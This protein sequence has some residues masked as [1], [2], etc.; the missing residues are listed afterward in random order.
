MCEEQ[1]N[2]PEFFQDQVEYLETPESFIDPL[3]PM[4][5]TWNTPSLDDMVA[6][7]DHTFS[8]QRMSFELP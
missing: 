7:L 3:A 5:P 8:Q 2:E 4:S 1:L 6:D